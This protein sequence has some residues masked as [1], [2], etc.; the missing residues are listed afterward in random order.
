MHKLNGLCFAVEIAS[1]LCC[2]LAL[3]PAV[4]LSPKPL[5]FYTFYCFAVALYISL[6]HKVCCLSRQR[7]RLLEMHQSPRARLLMH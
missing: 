1:E 7:F 6:F 2:F 3:L 4:S 5:T